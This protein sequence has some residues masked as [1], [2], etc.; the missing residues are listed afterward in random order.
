M[1]SAVRRKLAMA[2]R[3]R[4]FFR[5]HPSDEP[6]HQEVLGK[7]E[8]RLA[9]ADVLALQ[10]RAGIA[11][12]GAAVERRTELRRRIKI[13]LLPHL[14]RVG[15]VVATVRPELAGRFR[16]PYLGEPLRTFS[17]ATREMLALASAD[18][19]LFEAKG[20]SRALLD[21]L[22]ETFNAFEQA[23]I[24]SHDGRSSH[25]GASADLREVARELVKLVGQLDGLNRFRFRKDPELRAAWESARDVVGPFGTSTLKEPEEGETPPSGGVAPAA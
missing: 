22:T 1:L 19:E 3:V 13:E 23:T 16:V 8:E 9:R 5:T 21:E 14:V 2:A 17:D 24:A 25:V 12:K 10:Q 6:S 15:Q 7:L 4:D 11:I 18:R 20:L